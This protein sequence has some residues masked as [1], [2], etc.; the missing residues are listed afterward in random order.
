MYYG[1][2]KIIIIIVVVILLLLAIAGGVFAYLF[3]ATDTFK[4]EQTLFYKYM[5]QGLGSVKLETNSQLL[6]YEKLKG[7][8]AYTIDGNI[9]ASYENTGND[10]RNEAVENMRIKV[11]GRVDETNKEA[12]INIK[13]DNGTQTVMEADL[14]KS[15]NILAFYSP[16]IITNYAG[17]RNEK[18]TDFW[19]NIDMT[20]NTPVLPNTIQTIALMSLLSVT[21][22]ER[23]NI[24]TTYGTVLQEN[25]P[26]TNY[27]KQSKVAVKKNGKNYEANT[28]R[29]DLSG[30]EVNTVVSKLL[31]TLKQDSVTLN[32]ITTKAKALGL[33]EEYTEINNLTKGIQ[34]QIDNLSTTLEGLSSGVSIIVYEVD[35]NTILTEIVAKNQMKLTIDNEQK[36][37]G[38]VLNIKIDNLSADESYVT[39]SIGIKTNF[40]DS[41][42]VTEITINKDETNTLDIM[43]Q[44]E[45]TASLKTMKNTYNITYTNE[46]GITSAE[47]VEDIAFVDS[48]EKVT[49]LDETNTGIFNEYPAEQTNSIVK[50]IIERIKSVVTKK[51]EEM[52]IFSEESNKPI[53]DEEQDNGENTIT[54]TITNTET[55]NTTT[56]GTENVVSNNTTGGS[57]TTLPIIIGN[58]VQ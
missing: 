41:Q 15:N 14:T 58:T 57:N 4:S 10:T 22:E 29:L 56:G 38:Q 2:K 46:Q 6:N 5:G 20:K 28:Y 44:N 26:E 35:G 11:A 51:L 42:T 12:N 16:E 21:E 3:L 37:N 39:L 1:K 18:L 49:K 34:Y 50:A 13:L 9:T 17:I 48:I 55:T 33:S 8:S 52:G 31:Q 54:N 7:Q 23:Q 40:T 19:K 24:M 30:A 32:M 47:Y 27:K 53:T 43:I 45:G 36:A 25:I